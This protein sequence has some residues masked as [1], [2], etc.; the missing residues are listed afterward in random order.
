MC[1]NAFDLHVTVSDC[2]LSD[3]ARDLISR[4]GP[5]TQDF[6]RILP[7]LAPA[8]AETFMDELL[9]KAC[10]SLSTATDVHTSLHPSTVADVRFTHLCRPT[11]QGNG[12]LDVKRAIVQLLGR[13]QTGG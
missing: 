2:R 3:A 10:A 13:P 6:A 1:I 11:A 8:R 12:K 4:K 9:G 7:V 5:Y